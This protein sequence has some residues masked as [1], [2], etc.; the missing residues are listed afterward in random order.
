MDPARLRLAA[1]HPLSIIT[2]RNQGR[3][4]VFRSTGVP[5]VPVPARPGAS[6]GRR[7]PG[8]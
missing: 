8:R 5:I 1:N 4:P 7:G 2:T 3:W 6:S